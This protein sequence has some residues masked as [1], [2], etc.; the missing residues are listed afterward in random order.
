MTAFCVF[1]ITRSQCKKI[2][3]EKTPTYSKELKRDFTKEEFAARVEEMAKELFEA[4]VR[5][6]QISPAFDTPHFAEDW[7]SIGIK[8]GEIRD[9]KIMK[10]GTKTDKH[11]NL[12]S[13]KKTGLAV[14]SW[15]P[16]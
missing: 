15:I 7:I 3:E 1:G 5:T 12:K 2:A 8:A 16:Y 10:R 4:G 9:A 6:K 11:G 14:I 13:N